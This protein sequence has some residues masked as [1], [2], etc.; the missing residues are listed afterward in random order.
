MAHTDLQIVQ[1]HLLFSMHM[2]LENVQAGTKA[3]T[4]TGLAIRAAQNMGLHRENDSDAEACMHQSE[5]RRRV[6]GGC[7]IADRWISALV[8]FLSQ[9]AFAPGSNAHFFL[10]T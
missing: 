1:A 8:R 5:L 7:I 4:S 2:D 9:S 10:S 3:W 6:W